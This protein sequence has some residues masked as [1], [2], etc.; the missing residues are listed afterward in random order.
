MDFSTTIICWYLQNK[1]DLPWRNTKNAY[2][3]WLSEIILQQTRIAQGLPYY[4]KF[5]EAFPTIENLAKSPEEKVL[6]L[7]QGLGYYSRARNL[8]ETAKHIFFN[9]NNKFPTTYK[10][11]LTLKGVGEYTAAAIASFSFNENIAVVDGNVFRVLARYFGIEN[12][13]SKNKTKK[14]FQQVANNL[15]PKGKAAT[16]NQA[17][18]EF[19]ALQCVP[20]KPTCSI[21]VLQTSCYALQRN[22]IENLPVKSKKV[23][24]KKRY[25]NYFV[26]TDKNEKYIIEQRT[27]NDIWKN[28]Y[29]FPLL[30]TK[31]TMSNTKATEYINKKYK[32][33]NVE[34]INN[35]A[36]IHK[37]SHQHLYITF[38][39]VTVSNVLSQA[40]TK[41]KMKTKPFPIILHNFLENNLFLKNNSCKELV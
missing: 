39:K 32:K 35:R 2:N 18:M 19:G 33:A 31:K 30:E 10:E 37:L 15:L 4:T 9:L 14:E 21:C 26:V 34:I 17:I 40:V 13:I 7:W 6:K 8:H 41:E 12:D 11:L 20:Q 27:S 23:T 28:L 5:I 29:Q 3:I 25:F 1:R 16:F 36:V 22:K 24:I 38:Y